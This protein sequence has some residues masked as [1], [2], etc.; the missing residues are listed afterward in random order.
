MFRYAS[1][2]RC[3]RPIVPFGVRREI[4]ESA[5]NCC[6]VG[7][8]ILIDDV[9]HKVTKTQQGGRGR[10][11][12]F[13]K[14]TVQNLYSWKNM[15]KTFKSTDELEIPVITFEEAQ[16][17]WFDSMAGEYVSCHC[18]LLC[19][20]WFIPFRLLRMLST[21]VIMQ[22]FMD[23]NTFEEVRVQNVSKAEFLQEGQVVTMQKFGDRIVDTVLPTSATYTVV[24]VNDAAPL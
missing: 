24:S 8:Y 3:V 5:W 9:P 15:E 23:S 1:A 7:K 19:V 17:S 20:R 2:L 11:A 4:S 6:K 21:L 18:F 12:S 14:C 16:F 10:G 22:V 13:V